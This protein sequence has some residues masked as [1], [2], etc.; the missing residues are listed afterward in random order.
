LTVGLDRWSGRPRKIVFAAVG[1]AVFPVWTGLI[2]TAVVAHRGR[3]MLFELTPATVGITF[4]GHVI[5]GLVLGAIFVRARRR[6]GGWPWPRRGLLHAA[7]QHP[8]ELQQALH[9][10]QA[11]VVD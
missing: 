4:V 9:L 6:C 11:A 8:A 5:F 10:G 1:F 2:A 7:R 3:H